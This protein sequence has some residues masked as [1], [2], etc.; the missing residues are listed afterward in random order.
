MRSRPC[1]WVSVRGLQAFD[2][3]L[4]CGRPEH[5]FLRLHARRIHARA[6]RPAGNSPLRSRLRCDNC[7]AE[8]LLA[9]SCKR[10]LKEHER[11]RV[12]RSAR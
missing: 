4:Q 6:S 9:F 2:G 11:K 10:L 5:A 3:Y 8:H 1:L 12:K 7:R